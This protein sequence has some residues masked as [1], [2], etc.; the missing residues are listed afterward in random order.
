MYKVI[1]RPTIDPFV[2]RNSLRTFRVE[3]LFCERRGGTHALPKQTLELD[4]IVW[5]A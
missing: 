4:G 1:L 2:W 3:S 5:E